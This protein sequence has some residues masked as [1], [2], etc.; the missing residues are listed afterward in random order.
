MTSPEPT[1]STA[2]R[3][4]WW[5][6]AGVGVVAFAVAHLVDP[7]AWQH[8]R[9]PQIYERDWG[10]LLRVTGFLPTWLVVAVALWAT[11]RPA[12]GWGWRGG[13]MAAGPA[14][15]GL[16]AEVAKLLIRRLRPDPDVFGYAFRAF[17]DHPWSNRGMGVP[18]SHAMVAF[19][20]AVV[21][22]R[23]FPRARAL[24]YLL[25]AGCAATR[26]LALGHFVSDVV[27]AAVLSWLV[28]AP[29]A[30]RMLARWREAAAVPDAIRAG[31]TTPTHRPAPSRGR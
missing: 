25:A 12:R 27:A 20:A 23:L 10:R 21:L 14:L 6:V 4:P 30:D 2:A 13:A 31:G 24:W 5:L 26:V 19:S 8:W 17:A 15:G 16:T 1:P 11:D 28:T 22:S 29:L 3:R 18:S 9:D 7:V